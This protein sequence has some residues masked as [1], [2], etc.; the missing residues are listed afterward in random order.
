MNLATVINAI[1]M[2]GTQVPEFVALIE[3]VK[4][5]FSETDQAAIDAIMRSADA[6]ADAQHARAQA[7]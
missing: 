7:S 2:V 5:S 1:L 3:E 6:T 4:A